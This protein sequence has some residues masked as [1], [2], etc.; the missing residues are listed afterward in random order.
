MSMVKDKPVWISKTYF[1]VYFFTIYMFKISH[2]FFSQMVYGPRCL[3][4][5]PMMPGI[6]ST[7]AKHNTGSQQRTKKED[8]LLN[9]MEVHPS[10]VQ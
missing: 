10:P 9:D 2:C 6:L 7:Q 1:L 3:S 5:I 4:T 8:Q